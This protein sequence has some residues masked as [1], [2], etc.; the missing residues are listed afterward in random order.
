MSNLDFTPETIIS[1][2]ENAEQLSLVIQ[3][4]LDQSVPRE[5]I[6]PIAEK[7]NSDLQEVL[8]L[9]RLAEHDAKGVWGLPMLSAVSPSP[10]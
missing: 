4:L 5:N 7:L 3:M 9:M 1:N 10:C 2:L 6:L 8:L